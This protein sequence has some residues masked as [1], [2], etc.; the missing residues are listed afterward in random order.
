MCEDGSLF[1]S[2]LNNNSLAEAALL[3][4]SFTARGGT[5][6]HGI[7]NFNGS[8]LFATNTTTLGENS[9]THAIG[10]ANYGVASLRGGAFTGSGGVN[11]RGIFNSNSSSVIL[12]ANSVTAL[13]RDG[14][15]ANY[16]LYNQADAIVTANSSQ[17]IG[18]TNGLSLESGSVQLGSSLLDSG[19][20]RSGGSLTCFQVY[21]E[22]Y[23]AYMCP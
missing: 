23:A 3:G 8:I 2:G 4:S 18:G 5:S 1:N 10:L 21:D 17:F 7:T 13:G 19:A 12:D 6:A 22:L 9:A 11:A 16:G 14:S 15:G 20:T